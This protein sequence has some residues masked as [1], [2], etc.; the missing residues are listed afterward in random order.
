[1]VDWIL[2][3]VNPDDYA[4]KLTREVEFEVEASKEDGQAS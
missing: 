4:K 3:D 1:L 2:H